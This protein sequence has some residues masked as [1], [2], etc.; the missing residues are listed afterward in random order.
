MPNEAPMTVEQYCR[1]KANEYLTK[2]QN[3][4]EGSDTRMYYMGQSDAFNEVL[5]MLKFLEVRR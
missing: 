4:R 1:R 5:S 2:A 3:F